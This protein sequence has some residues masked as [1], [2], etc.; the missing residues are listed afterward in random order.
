MSNL[1]E[2]VSIATQAVRTLLAVGV[3]AMVGGGIWYGSSLLDSH[4]REAKEAAQALAAVR[5]DLERAESTLV[6]KDEQISSLSDL[7][8]Q[9]QAEIDRLDAA[10]HLLKI[11]HRVAVLSVSEQKREAETG[12]LISTI[13]FQELDDKGNAVGPAK[14]FQIPG[15]IVYIDSWTVKFDDKYVEQ[16]DMHR[17]TSLVLFRRI[18][19]ENQRPSEAFTLDEA[20]SRPHI[21]GHGDRM[22]EWERQIWDDF[23]SVAN[24][25]QRQ[26]E[27]GIRAAHGEAPSIRVQPGKSYRISIRASGGLAVTVEDSPP[28]QLPPPT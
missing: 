21:Y 24:D 27:L 28:P 4:E 23:W 1:M 12:Q 22:S 10:M 7:V 20:G 2:N 14:R 13:D 18:F 3:C 8:D 6:E 5:A 15:D 9:K 17:S 16:A 19:G 11:D 25:Q 26:Q